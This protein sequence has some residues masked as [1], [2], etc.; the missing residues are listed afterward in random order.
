MKFDDFQIGYSGSYTTRMTAEKNQ[1]FGELTGD[2]NPIHFD[3]ERMKKTI[4]GKCAINGL[5]TET[6][7]GAALVKM[8]TSDETL[9]IALK[10]ENKLLNPVFIGDT[11]TATVKVTERYPEKQRLLC[12]CLTKNQDGK[13]VIDSKFL[14]KILNA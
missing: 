5:F 10:Q 7:I 12:N 1:K 13:I 2:F 6:A 9:I 8:F 4:F 3:E 11:I 14:I